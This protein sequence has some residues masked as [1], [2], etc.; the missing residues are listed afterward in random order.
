MNYLQLIPDVHRNQ[1]IIKV[2]FNFD[3]DLIALVKDQKGVSYLK[4]IQRLLAHGNS[5]TTEIH[6]H[7]S[8]KFLENKQI[9]KL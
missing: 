7:F 6:T 4:Y 9:T 8:K 2:D 3:K 5:K 1:P